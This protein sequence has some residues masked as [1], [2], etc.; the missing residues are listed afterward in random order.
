LAFL[1]VAFILPCLSALHAEE[2][3]HTPARPTEEIV[4]SCTNPS[5]DAEKNALYSLINAESHRNSSTVTSAAVSSNS[6]LLAESRL[7]TMTVSG[8]NPALKNICVFILV[9]DR[10]DEPVK[11]SKGGANTLTQPSWIELAHVISITR[12]TNSPGVPSDGT[13]KIS[14]VT[15][16]VPGA[17]LTFSPRFWISGVTLYIGIFDSDNKGSIALA[18][19]RTEYVSGRWPAVFLTLIFAIVAYCLATRCLPIGAR[20]RPFNPI[21]VTAGYGGAP[22]LSQLQVFLF[23]ITVASLL[24]YIWL[25]LG[26]LSEISS[27]L[28]ILMGISAGGALGAKFA[29]TMKKSD[30]SQEARIFLASRRWFSGKKILPDPEQSTIS[31]LLKT[32]DRLD[33]YKLQMAVFTVVVFFYILFSGGYDLGTVRISET[34]LYLMGISQGIYV[35]SKAID[36]KVTKLDVDALALKKLAAEHADEAD[37]GEKAKLAEKFTNLAN[38]MARD[39]QGIYHVTVEDDKRRP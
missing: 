11:N 6:V 19:R 29:T 34:L 33:I 31:E 38:D 37:P 7:A 24:F 14:F 15:P 13:Y 21:Y 18:A 16:D 4:K 22:S 2:P 20:K 27:D 35:G 32:D 25:R 17:S 23:T 36:D 8:L 9:V 39:F 30:L 10:N 26:V 1:V 3:P 28:L 12:V 5:K